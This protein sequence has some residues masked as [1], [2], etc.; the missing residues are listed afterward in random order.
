MLIK[1]LLDDFGVTCD[2]ANDRV[3]AAEMYN[4]DIHSLTLMNENTPNMSGLE[5]MKII[6]EKY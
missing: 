5:A 4:P 1:M 6:R 3:K 2:I